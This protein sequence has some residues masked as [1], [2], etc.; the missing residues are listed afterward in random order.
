M[1]D[2]RGTSQKRSLTWR[3]LVPGLAAIFFLMAHGPEV[4]AEETVSPPTD[5]TAAD[6]GWDAGGTIKVTWKAPTD[7]A[8]TPTGYQI[9]RSETPSETENRESGERGEAVQAVYDKAYQNEYDRLVD[10]EGLAPESAAP[11]AREVARAAARSDASFAPTE[12]GPHGKH[13]VMVDTFGP[14]ADSAEIKNLVANE[15]FSFIVYSLGKDAAGQP[16]RSVASAASGGA[17]AT[18]SAFDGNRL[19]LFIF[20]HPVLRPSHFRIVWIQH[21][22]EVIGPLQ[23]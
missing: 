22:F 14:D 3:T 19:I 1:T 12:L 10:V 20:N 7:S 9:W 4:R 16:V 18:A 23:F 15:P 13:W 17:E 21:M 5:V 11:T 8:I 2:T 6:V